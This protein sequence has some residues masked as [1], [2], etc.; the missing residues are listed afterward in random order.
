MV[1][2]SVLIPSF[3]VSHSL[4]HIKI[5]FIFCSLIAPSGSM[6]GFYILYFLKIV[7]IAPLPDPDVPV[8]KPFSS[9]I[10]A[11]DVVLFKLR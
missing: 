2:M 11:L 1:L 8:M 10:P 9:F 5:T 6:L 7:K 3:L 4:F